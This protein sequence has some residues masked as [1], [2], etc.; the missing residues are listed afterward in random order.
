MLVTPLIIRHKLRSRQVQLR[1]LLHQWLVM[2]P[3][4]LKYGSFR[5]LHTSSRAFNTCRLS[6]QSGL[7]LVIKLY[8][9]ILFP[10]NL[11]NAVIPSKFDILPAL[12]NGD[13][14]GVQA[15]IA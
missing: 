11:F 12:K 4:R 5:R 8:N 1:M 6:D 7:L 9:V 13:S 14:Y 10:T 15:T 2:I 3:T